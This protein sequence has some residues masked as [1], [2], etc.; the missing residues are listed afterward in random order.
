VSTV[1]H[2]HLCHGYGPIGA[3][4]SLDS[5]RMLAIVQPIPG[6]TVPAF[7]PARVIIDRVQDR[8]SRGECDLCSEVQCV[9]AAGLV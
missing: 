2:L 7:V 8:P 4:H 5:R 3:N 6:R 1:D 9:S